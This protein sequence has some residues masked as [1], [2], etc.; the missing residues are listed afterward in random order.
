[1]DGF[2]SCSMD[3]F[4]DALMTL[5]R[6]R[7]KCPWSLM[8]ISLLWSFCKK[9]IL[10]HD[11]IT[12]IS[13]V[14]QREFQNPVVGGWNIRLD[15]LA[16]DSTGKHYNL[17]V[18]KKPE[19]AHIRRARFHSSMMD[20]RMLKEGQEFSKLRDSYMVFIT[21]TGIFGHGIPIYT[22]NRYFEEIGDPFDDGS[23]IVYVNGTKT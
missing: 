6:C 17:E 14:G 10:K 16:K 22:I 4:D 5:Y 7:S 23:H 15:I 20:S 3:L 9:I 8:A 2:I 13:V 12:V 11:D 18:Q 19:G 1:M 21:R